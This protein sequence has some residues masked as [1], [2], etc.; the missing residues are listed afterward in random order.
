MLVARAAPTL[1][2]PLLAQPPGPERPVL[3]TPVIASRSVPRRWRVSSWALW[4][5]GDAGPTSF[6]AGTLGGAQAGMRGTWDIA[7]DRLPRVAVA[8]R[9]SS[10]LRRPGAEAAI[11]VEWQP[12]AA[13]PVRVLAERRQRVSGDGRSAFALLA[14]GGMSDVA[15]PLRFDLDAYGAA[16]VV[17]ARRRDLFAEGAVTAT[18]PIGP[19]K[20]GAGA[21]G[22]AQPGVA[23]LD[24]GPTFALPLKLGPVNSRLS[25]DYRVRV[26]GE[27]SPGSGPA[28][29]LG[30]DF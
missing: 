21:W 30:A 20:A 4:R 12:V 25:L 19:L 26:A 15:L 22:G 10:S 5:P 7:P 6:G 8:A 16:G 14:H 13:V 27:A 24:V 2:A 28:L 18:R 23:R 11:G 9:L 1:V 3:L 29:T 17:G